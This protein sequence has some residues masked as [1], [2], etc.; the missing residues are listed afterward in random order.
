MATVKN[1]G[2]T[3]KKNFEGIFPVIQMPY[4]ESGAIDYDTLGTEIDFLFTYGTHGI[5]FALVSE[6]LRLSSGERRRISVELP[7]LVQGRGMVIISAGAETTQEAVQYA[8]YAAENGADAVMAIPPLNTA[9][10]VASKTDYFRAI[11]DAID[12]PLIVQD[13]SG[14]MGG[15]AMSPELL[16]GLHRELGP[17]IMF[18]PEGHPIGQTISAL[19]RELGDDAVILEGSGGYLLIDSIRRGVC[20]TMPGA[21][22]ICGISAIW[23]AMRS[24]EENKAYD[25]YFPLSAIVLLQLH[26]LDAFLAVE[27]YLLKKQGIFQNEIVRGPVGYTLDNE[28]RAEIDRLYDMMCEVIEHYGINSV[29]YNEKS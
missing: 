28:T 3:Y 14:Y 2:N 18:K 8:E 17:R 20:G 12:I 11:H 13:A 15:Q 7:A 29:Q 25:I 16:A 23:N 5:T 24:G 21:D 4:L 10:S 9:L 22:L 1:T 27:K 19:L 26:S 6:L